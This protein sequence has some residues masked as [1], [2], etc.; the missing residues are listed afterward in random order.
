MYCTVRLSQYTAFHLLHRKLR[1]VC[2]DIQAA[3]Y[4]IYVRLQSVILH[5]LNGPFTAPSGSTWD[6]RIRWSLER[7]SNIYFT[8]VMRE[9][10]FCLNF[11]RGKSMRQQ[12]N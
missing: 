1:V 6:L 7:K 12:I 8:F 10:H 5:P 11:V 9:I 4:I 3:Q 2:R